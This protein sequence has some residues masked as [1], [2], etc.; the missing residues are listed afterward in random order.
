[1][2]KR[3]LPIIF[4]LISSQVFSGTFYSKGNLTANTPANWNSATNGTGTDATTSNFTDGSTFIIQSGN[5]MT[6]NGAFSLTGTGSTLQINS[7]GSLTISN[8]T[9]IVNIIISGTLTTNGALLVSGNW[10]NN[11]ATFN[12]NSNTV[13][14][15]GIIQQEVNGTSNTT[16]GSVVVSTGATLLGTKF[17]GCNQAFTLNGTAT[18]IQM[19]GTSFPANGAKS[20][21]STSTYIY[22]GPSTTTAP[23]WPGVSG[24]NFGNLTINDAGT[25]ACYT[26]LATVTGNLIVKNNVNLLSGAASITIGGNLQL[27]SGTLNFNVNSGIATI[28]VGGNVI[29]NGGILNAQPSISAPNFNVKGNW[30]TNTGAVFNPGSTTVNLNGS[31]TQ[32]INGTA[33]TTFYG[34]TLSTSNGTGNVVIAPN[35]PANNVTVTNLLTLNSR[36][37][38]TGT[39]T[40]TI[41]GSGL[42]IARTSGWVNGN[43][44]K[45]TNSGSNAGYIYPIGDALNYT[46][47]TVAFTNNATSTGTVT[48]NTTGT[49]HP[50]IVTSGLDKNEDVNRYWTISNSGLAFAGTY[51]AAFSF[52]NA[53]PVD[54]DANTTQTN[55]VVHQFNSVWSSP[56]TSS[57]ITSKTTVTGLTSFGDFAVGELCSVPT[58]VSNFST[59]AVSTCLGSGAV[60][61]INSTS[62][63]NGNTFNVIYNLSGATI[64]TDTALITLASN[65]ASFTTPAL[66]N[67]GNTTVIITGIY[68]STCGASVVANNAALFNVNML[69]TMIQSAI[70]PTCSGAT[71]FIIP[72]TS[73]TANKYSIS[74]SGILVFTNGLLSAG[75]SSIVVNLANPALV[76]TLY[77]N[78]VLLDSTTGCI[79]SSINDS[80]VV[81][82][83]PAI[84]LGAIAPIC[85]GSTSFTI[86]YSS[87]TGD[88]YSISGTNIATVINGSLTNGISSI[89]VNLNSA[90]LSGNIS[91]VLT[92]RNSVTGCNSSTLLDTV[93]IRTSP[94]LI[95]N[96]IASI[97]T[98]STSF[99]IPYSSV[100]ANEY[101]ISGS[102]IT[103]VTNGLLT[104]SLSA[105]KVSLNTKPSVGTMYF[106]LTVNDTTTGCISS[107]LY[108]SIIVTPCYVDSARLQLDNVFQNIDKTQIPTGYLD[109]YGTQFIRKD[110]FNG[111][112]AD[113]NL[114]N[115]T[116]FRFIYADISSAKI[117]PSANSIPD[118]TTVNSEIIT[119]KQ[120][121]SA[122]PLVLFFGQYA[123][124]KPNGLTDNLFTMNNNQL[125][126]VPNRIQSPYVQKSVFAATAA[127]ASGYFNNGTI[128]LTYNP[129]L[130]YTNTNN[131]ISSI[132]IDFMDGQGIQN[133]PPNGTLNKIYTDSDGEKEFIIQVILDNGTVLQCYSVAI[134]SG[135]ITNQLNNFNS[136]LRPSLNS[137]TLSQTSARYSLVLSDI[138]QVPSKTGDP[139]DT[140]KMDIRYSSNNSTTSS[141]TFYVKKAFIIL[142][143]YDIHDIS[144]DLDP[145]AYTIGDLIG[146]ATGKFGEWNQTI[147]NLNDNLNDLLNNAG[148]DLIFVNYNTMKS[149]EDNSIVIERVIEWVNQQ[150]ASAGSTEK[151]VVLG[152]SEGGVVARYT[153]AKM[154]TQLGSASTDTRLLI[155]Q[156]AP[157]QGANVPLG[158]QHAL[159][160]LGSAKIMGQRISDLAASLGDFYTLN[161]QPATQ[162]LLKERVTSSD[163]TVANNTFMDGPYRQMIDIPVT[164]SQQPMY[165]FIATSQGSQ[166]GIP[167]MEAGTLLANFSDDFAKVFLL[168]GYFTNNFILDLDLNATSTNSNQTIS[169]VKIQRH[170]QIFGIGL[171][172]KTLYSA[173]RYTPSNTTPWDGVPGGTESILASS[174]GSL[175]IHGISNLGWGV[176]ANGTRYENKAGYNININLI[177]DLFCF[178]PAISALDAPAGTDPNSQ[179]YIYPVTTTASKAS[180]FIAQ[181]AFSDFNNVSQTYQTY[182][183]NI[184]TTFSSRNSEWIYDAMEGINESLSCSQTDGCSAPFTIFGQDP[185][186]NSSLF[187]TSQLTPDATVTW[188]IS[189]TNS[190]ALTPQG[191]NVLITNIGQSGVG[192]LTATVT[193]KCGTITHQ[194]KSISIGNPVG[195][196]S[197]RELGQTCEYDVSVSPVEDGNTYLWSLNGRTYTSEIPSL[198]VGQSG[199]VWLEISNACGNFST[200]RPYN[201]Q[202]APNGANCNARPE[203][204]G[205]ADSSNEKD[206]DFSLNIYPNP[207][208]NNLNVI[209]K[210][211]QSDEI[212]TQ[213]IKEIDIFNVSGS[214]IKT[215]KFSNNQNININLSNILAGE[216][217][218]KVF[219]GLTWRVE[220]FTKMSDK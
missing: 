184:H 80:V 25:I 166:C 198:E 121:L 39:N 133:L 111:V 49:E 114:V 35:S 53:T 108:D 130:F 3:L 11:G 105:L 192:T 217:I 150:K 180:D 97:C 174:G 100:S 2:K 99:V 168:N 56:T 208:S 147:P 26:N 89:T 62:L 18:F 154:T 66:M 72:Y 85:P 205:E 185:I 134:V 116:S 47:V 95:L 191:N 57:A 164:A 138:Q 9:S 207:T 82:A 144:P 120:N 36:K 45:T 60:V 126:D 186:C 31:S 188:S 54:V 27:D 187:S 71:S 123:S 15:N 90:T 76:G 165:R 102:N 41:A 16:F 153:L 34:L 131:T 149:V 212:Q 148:Y 42:A 178:V 172:F 29:V 176:I 17:L 112:I 156:D 132:G 128:S 81:N 86:P 193:D 92:I 14:F 194:S 22:K 160:D 51:S 67:T 140:T 151:N 125:F 75:A 115:L 59:S 139:F 104:G 199:T 215:E 177:Q 32:T 107:T 33:N 122:T 4:L 68:S 103:T 65:S 96:N 204:Y 190:A 73:T 158:Y 6:T 145:V 209:L 202:R 200:S 1:M 74:G 203:W 179:V 113:S 216:Y 10:T 7:G 91:F 142:K 169:H 157:H 143:G 129:S 119:A 87:T 28:T 196:I 146:D 61:T 93:N 101:S 220:K 135:V 189:P 219:D 77:S 197:I 20:L 13:T 52:I 19:L 98:D 161:S 118:I 117:L 137:S 88:Q 136:L 175:K 58:D 218:L 214:I 48:V 155:T 37:I 64:S 30:T 162:E 12:N 163:G 167:V 210:G 159:Y 63:G 43:L 109:E 78:L 69:P 23:G 183:N 127:T 8:T 84:T 70:L 173:D 171:G 106:T 55:F 94:S 124:L 182:Y 181:E 5:S 110:Y 211:V 213:M 46:P 24:I 50:Q 83:L 44:A 152:I 21:S 206:T 201:L 170:T 38:V 141:S 40:L 79:S 195:T